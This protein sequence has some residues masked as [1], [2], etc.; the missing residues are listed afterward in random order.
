M[1]RCLHFT[2]IET[3]IE[4]VDR[5]HQSLALAAIPAQVEGV[6][7]R[8]LA[9]I[10]GSTILQTILDLDRTRPIQNGLL[11][12]LITLTSAH[13]AARQR[14]HACD[15][16]SKFNAFPGL[17]ACIRR[18]LRLLRAG[19]GSSAKLDLLLILVLAVLIVSN[20]RMLPVITVVSLRIGPLLINEE[21][22]DVLH[23]HTHTHGTDASNTSE[24]KLIPSLIVDWCLVAVLFA[25]HCGCIHLPG[26]LLLS[27]R[28]KL[29]NN[30]SPASRTLVPLRHFLLHEA[31]D[32]LWL[33]CLRAGPGRARLITASFVVQLTVTLIDVASSS[34]HCED[35]SLYLA[36]SLSRMEVPIGHAS[37]L[38]MLRVGPAPLSLFTERHTGSSGVL[39]RRRALVVG[40]TACYVQRC[41]ALVRHLV[42]ASAAVVL[43]CIS[44]DHTIP[45]LLMRR[46][47]LLSEVDSLLVQYDDAV[48]ALPHLHRLGVVL[49]W[50]L[51]M[52][53]DLL[54]LLLLA[55]DKLLRSHAS[56]LILVHHHVLAP[57]I[58]DRLVTSLRRI[59]HTSDI[60][61]MSRA[62]G[63]DHTIAL[64]ARAILL[65][66][67][68]QLLHLTPLELSRLLELL[69]CSCCGAASGGT[70]GSDVRLGGS[71]GGASCLLLSGSAS[72]IR[73]SWWMAGRLINGGAL[74]W[75]GCDVGTVDVGVG[76]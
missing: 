43:A 36:S 73:G 1:N 64:G 31:G 72:R 40:P 14:L 62:K 30:L 16:D 67:L 23:I 5:A 25:S 49:P 59:L 51:R 69:C 70:S 15:L 12:R 3:L 53:D 6:V 42:L 8:I 65:L 4:L 76:R 47:L 68:V 27:T 37:W 58:R 66:L 2:D 60:R 74:R 71:S 9:I 61:P 57:W 20:L 26:S 39:V 21:F 29:P 41:L 24:I 45:R 19:G 54:P 10:S 46:G 35:L 52:I 38:T 7:Q 11:L 13:R 55:F 22:V 50:Q 48:G 33:S 63:A 75:S 32:H 18:S 28:A 34:G 17:V 56:N 44:D